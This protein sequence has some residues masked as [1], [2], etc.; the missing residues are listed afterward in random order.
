MEAPARP[1]SAV[2]W[3]IAAGLVLSFASALVPFFTAG[4]KLQFQVML[5]GML[6]YMVYGFAAPLLR[7]GLGITVGVLLVAAHTWLVISERFA[8]VGYPD[9][10]IYYVPLLLALLLSPLLFLALHKPY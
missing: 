1:A 3:I 8:G 5:A 10:L 4:Y 9:G 2:Y 7:R 6:P